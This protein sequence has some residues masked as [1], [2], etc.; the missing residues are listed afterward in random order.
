MNNID[1]MNFWI[2]SAENDYGTM[3][4]MFKNKK[5]SWSLFVGQLV[6]EKLLKA[7]YAKKNKNNPHVPRSH[8]LVYLADKCEIDLSFE[9]KIRLEMITKFCLS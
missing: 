2:E 5:Y 4:V 3:L 7:L 1:I 9:Q 8:D 6:I